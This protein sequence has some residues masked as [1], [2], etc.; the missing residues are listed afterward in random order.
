MLN[1]M[2]S[3]A[4]LAV[5]VQTIISSSKRANIR[6]LFAPF[7]DGWVVSA[8]RKFRSL[9]SLHMRLSIIRPLRGRE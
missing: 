9:R 5:Y 8:Y 3:E 7:G 4:E 2:W 1:R 6:L